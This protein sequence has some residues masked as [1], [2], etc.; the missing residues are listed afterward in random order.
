MT[1][2]LL[3]IAI[4]IAALTALAYVGQQVFHR[5]RDALFARFGQE[6]THGIE[7][8]ARSLSQD[9]ADIGEN[10][11]L[12]ATLLET[13]E[14][15]KQVERTLRAVATVKREYLALHARIGSETIRVTSID[16]PAEVNALAAETFEELLAAAHRQPGQLFISQ[17]F[18]TSGPA[19]WYRVFARQATS[20]GPAIA[21]AVDVSVMLP[22]LKLARNPWTARVILDGEGR[23]APGSDPAF[24]ALLAT[25]RSRFA[26]LLE[27]IRGGETSMAVLDAGTA[28]RMKL[29]E[30]PAVAVGTPIVVDRGPPW[31]LLVGNSTVSLD[32]QEHTII[33]RVLA[34]SALVLA[35]L[36]GGAAYVMHNTYRARALRDRVR[37]A[38]RIAHTGKLV[39]AGQLAAGI[40]HEIGTPLNVARGRVE[41]TLSHL[42]PTHPE[43]EN[44]R[45][46]IGEID[47]VTRL[48][49]QLLDYVRPAPALVEQVDL[50]ALLPTI[51]HLLSPQASK[52]GVALEIAPQPGR[53][54][55]N[56]DQIQQIMVNLTVNAIDACSS[57]GTVRLSS[58]VHEDRVVLE[59][60]DDG[61]GISREH[62]KQVFDPFFTTKKRGQGTGL[63]LWVVAQLARQQAAEIELESAPERGTT[64]R[65]TWPE[66]S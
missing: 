7:N 53:V 20:D 16:A 56:P 54:R 24:T 64:V 44:H 15:P 52:R 60:T 11:E 14:T 27:R 25:D 5:D 62:Q 18:A 40:A 39:T 1:P 35:L 59:V 63:G 50:G 9:I 33:Q 23:P 37:N 42:G 43:A 17:A 38:D 48:L 2:R 65:V 12:V 66:V 51:H 19:T 57:G 58:R 36:I 28:L 46:V 61:H 26:K 55:A 6:R 47:R 8:A 4:L 32:R 41:L 31:T 29:P 21:V 45:I 10:L 34:G 49:Q 3:V 22:R 30:S 13:T